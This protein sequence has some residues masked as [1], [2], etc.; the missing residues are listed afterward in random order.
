MKKFLRVYQKYGHLEMS[1][2]EMS[3]EDVIKDYGHLICEPNYTESFYGPV[4]KVYSLKD[5]VEEAATGDYAIRP[6]TLEVFTRI[7]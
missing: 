3:S 5:F 2:D 6:D 4:G 1:T 7:S